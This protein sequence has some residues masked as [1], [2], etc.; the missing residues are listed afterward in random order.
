MEK[1]LAESK[2]KETW[3][4]SAVSTSLPFPA[5]G[6]ERGF[7]HS[8]SPR[9]LFIRGP[10]WRLIRQIIQLPMKDFHTYLKACT[11]TYVVNVCSPRDHGVTPSPTFN[12]FCKKASQLYWIRRSNPC[13]DNAQE[14]LHYR[15]EDLRTQK[16]K[17]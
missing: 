12:S 16:F 17:F 2:E 1:F 13:D 10:R 11:S 4:H 5:E 6:E 9:E 8:S 14:H 15:H 7:K 3:S